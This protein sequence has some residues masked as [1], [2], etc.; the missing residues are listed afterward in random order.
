[1]IF[2]NRHSIRTSIFKENTNR[3]R[4]ITKFRRPFRID[5]RGLRILTISNRKRLL[6]FTQFRISTLRT[7][8]VLFMNNSTTRCITSVRLRCFVSNAFTNI[9]RLRTS[10][11]ELI[12]NSSS[13]N[14][15]RIK[16]LRNNMTWTMAR[17]MRYSIST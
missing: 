8:G 10:N 6:N 4:R 15:I 12:Q 3:R 17:K 14:S 9:N 7:Y 2:C 13:K 5:I 1:M 11:N 16:M